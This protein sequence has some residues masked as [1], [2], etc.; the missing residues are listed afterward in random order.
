M[1]NVHLHHFQTPFQNLINQIL[2]GQ[3]SM[4]FHFFRI[5]FYVSRFPLQ[6]F[7]VIPSL[8][9]NYGDQVHRDTYPCQTFQSGHW[10]DMS[11]WI[12]GFIPTSEEVAYI[13]T[14]VELEN[15]EAFVSH[16]IIASGNSDN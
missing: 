9:G 1:V 3:L 12:G 2:C 13:T 11:T 8:V 16:L 14:D 10:T 4:G 5:H 6:T 7:D 15:T